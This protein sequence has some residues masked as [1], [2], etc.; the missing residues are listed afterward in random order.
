M[1]HG[2]KM[3]I[4]CFAMTDPKIE[5]IYSSCRR[6]P[7]RWS[8]LLP[9]PYLSLSYD[10]SEHEEACKVEMDLVLAESQGWV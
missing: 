9:R 10:I 8:A 6:C 5:E 1:V 2:N 3:S 4:G 7:S